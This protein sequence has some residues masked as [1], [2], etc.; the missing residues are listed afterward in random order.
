MAG[1]GS[2][3]WNYVVEEFGEDGERKVFVESKDGRAE[4]VGK[5]LITKQSDGSVLRLVNQEHKWEY[6]ETEVGL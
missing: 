4:Q 5:K 6:D 3:W 1:G 2:H